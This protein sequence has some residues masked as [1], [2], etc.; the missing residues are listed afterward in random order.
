MN[1]LMIDDMI[2]PEK[3][4]P[5]SPGK[6][7]FFR[8]A[9]ENYARRFFLAKEFLRLGANVLLVRAEFCQTEEE[10][11]FDYRENSGISQVFVPVRKRKNSAPV[12]FFENADFSKALSDNS[13]S[14]SGLFAPDAVICSGVLPFSANAGAKI[15]ESAGAVLITEL[16]S[17]PAQLLKRTSLASALS[18][19]LMMLKRA[20]GNAFRK[21]DGVIGLF[22]GCS[23]LFSFVSNLFPME[24]SAFLPEYIP[25][26]EAKRK[27]S[28]LK[29]FSAGNTFVLA[30]PDPL[31]SGFSILELMEVS[32]GFGNKFALVFTGEG[33][34]KGAF[35]KAVSEKGYT[36]IFFMEEY[37][38]AEEEAFVLSAADG[39]FLSENSIEKGLASD[40]KRFFSAFGAGKPIVASAEN[41]AEIFRR[42]GGTIITKPKNKES[43]RL[44]I[45]TLMELS[46]NDRNILGTSNENF[47][48][49]NSAEKF[50]ADYYSIIENL[51]GQKEIKK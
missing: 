51:S 31:E 23:S 32:S 14:L 50:A 12:F 5:N 25:S 49:K 26:E 6:E 22:P 28:V 27:K 40:S 39:I 17:A 42:S 8:L 41:S 38:S 35:K 43:I 7:I 37:L 15:A 33:S 46:E 34:A 4:S 24:Y 19:V 48:K 18:P 13:K 29:A 9:K 21:S 20:L 10:L 47:A 16:C 3:F 44:G 2:L 1:I 11:P 30:C 45:K 36:N